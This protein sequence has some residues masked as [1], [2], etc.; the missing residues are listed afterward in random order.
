MLVISWAA[1]L[2][3]GGV[4]SLAGA[5]YA[6]NCRQIGRKAFPLLLSWI[7]EERKRVRWAGAITGSFYDGLRAD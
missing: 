7:E 5:R 1:L 6:H 3:E 2:N 4:G